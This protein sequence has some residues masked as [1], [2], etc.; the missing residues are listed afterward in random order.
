MRLTELL[1]DIEIISATADM[2]TDITGICYDSRKVEEGNL[3]VAVKG[4]SSDG[5][6]FIPAAAEKGAAA[7]LCEDIPADGTPYVQVKDCRLAL[8]LS[9]RNFYGNPAAEMTVIGI[10]GTSGKT[11]SSYLI[12]HMLEEKLGA[13]VGLM[14]SP[15]ECLL[16]SAGT[17]AAGCVYH[18]L[19][20]RAT[21]KWKQRA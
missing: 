17:V 16:W 7:V 8:A 4:F 15:M 13:K 18:M 2:N 20:V 21:K 10:T 19:I 5:H 9:S 11:T 14:N 6:R 1:Q 3:F 12:R